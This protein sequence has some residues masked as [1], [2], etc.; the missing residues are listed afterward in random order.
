MELEEGFSSGQYN[1]CNINL[2]YPLSSFI[3]NFKLLLCLNMGVIL[4]SLWKGTWGGSKIYDIWVSI[5][6]AC[7]LHPIKAKSNLSL[8]QSSTDWVC[9]MVADI[10][11]VKRFFEEYHES[12]NDLIIMFL[13]QPLHGVAP[14]MTLPSRGKPRVELLVLSLIS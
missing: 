9:P 4:W 5:K 12:P 14:L 7:K 11:C 2:L 6:I 8:L 3:L 1:L 10:L 13:E